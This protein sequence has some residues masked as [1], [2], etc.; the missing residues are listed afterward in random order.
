[1]GKN[2]NELFGLLSFFL[3]LLRLI[4]EF[5]LPSLLILD[6]RVDLKRVLIGFILVGDMSMQK[7]PS[8]MCRFSTNNLLGGVVWI[9]MRKL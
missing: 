7:V 5:C 6:V 8:S 1:M 2:R 3:Q 4:F 9:S